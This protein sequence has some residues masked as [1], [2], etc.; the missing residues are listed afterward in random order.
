MSMVS[1]LSSYQLVNAFSPCV[2]KIVSG[3]SLRVYCLK[4][5]TI[6]VHILHNYNNYLPLSGCKG[7]SSTYFSHGT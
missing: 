7:L 4:S 2:Y 6:A 1:Q 5:D 3:N